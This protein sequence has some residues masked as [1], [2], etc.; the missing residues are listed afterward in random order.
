MS[1]LTELQRIQDS[2]DSIRSVLVSWGVANSTDLIDELSTKLA[3]VTN[4]SSVSVDLDEGGVY[5]IPAGYHDGS[6]AV[7]NVT[8][9]GYM[10]PVV[11]DNKI[12][13]VD[14]GVWKYENPTNT[15]IDIYEVESGN[16]YLVALGGIVGSRFRSMFTTDNIVGRT[17]NSTGNMIINVNNPAAYSHATY[18]VP[19][20]G[21]ILVAK[22]NV[23]VSG[24]KSYVYNCTEKWL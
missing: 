18:T 3:N 15:Y 12:G 24:I 16:T 11:F 19:S 20:D 2:R 23:G 17:R 1:N 22:D 14:N 9:G 13:Y 4:F 21:Y 7:R 5:T 8:H 6:G 10:S